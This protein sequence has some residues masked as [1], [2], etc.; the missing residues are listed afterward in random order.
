M[1]KYLAAKVAEEASCWAEA[2]GEKEDE[3]GKEKRSMW[4]TAAL[5]STSSSI[6]GE[7]M[8]NLSTFGNL[9]MLL[10]KPDAFLRFQPAQVCFL[11]I[12]LDKILK[13][14]NNCFLLYDDENHA[15]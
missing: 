12:F 3:E 1:T 2:L 13:L 10:V 6:M 5:T 4:E 15:K 14:V 8:D 11:R 9:S 7:K